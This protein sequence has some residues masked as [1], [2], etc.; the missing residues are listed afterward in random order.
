MQEPA[1]RQAPSAKVQHDALLVVA[2]NPFADHTKVESV[3][4]RSG[5]VRLSVS[6]ALGREVALLISGEQPAGRYSHVFKAGSLP[7][8]V[9]LLRFESNGTVVSVP[10]VVQP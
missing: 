1:E 2:P 9:Y 8:G 10:L 5:M 7:A 4:S 3:V 6:D